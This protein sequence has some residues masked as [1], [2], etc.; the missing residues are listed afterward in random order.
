VRGFD[1][2]DDGGLIWYDLTEPSE[3]SPEDLAARCNAATWCASCAGFGTN[4][5]LKWYIQPEGAWIG[6]PWKGPC[7]GMYIKK[8]GSYNPGRPMCIKKKGS[9]NPGRLLCIEQGSYN[10]VG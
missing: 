10:L 7:A 6:I 5:V 9:Y 1:S 3:S 2:L 8:K 4:G